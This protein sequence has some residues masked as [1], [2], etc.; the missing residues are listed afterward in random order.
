MFISICI[1]TYSRLEYLKLSVASC[2]EQTY[3]N[4]E[5]CISQNPSPNEDDS[6]MISGWCRELCS[7]YDF[8]SFHLNSYNLGMAGNWN[9]CMKMAQGDYLIILGD[10]DLIA[11]AYLQI[12][13]PIIE[14]LK[15]DVLFCNQILLTKMVLY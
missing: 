10:D 15:A 8:V 6:N 12:M 5:I 4:F 7:K 1:P 2:L 14:K 13:V 11:P 9:E 3:K